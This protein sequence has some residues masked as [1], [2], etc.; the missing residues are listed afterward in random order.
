[1]LTR[2][3]FDQACKIF[4]ESN[5]EWHWNEHPSVSDLGYLSRTTTYLG[6]N[7]S[8]VDSDDNDEASAPMARPVLTSQQF[9]VFSATFQVPCFYFTMYHSNGAPLSLNELLSTTLLRASMLE[10]TE[11][12]SFAVTRQ[13]AMFPLLSQGEHPTTGRPCWYLHPCETNDAVEEMLREVDESEGE[14]SLAWLKMWIV[15]LGS[16]VNL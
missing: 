8:V 16:A 3:Q 5:S 12:T 11:S 2:P 15:V 6:K 9:I 10:N 13:N 7:V 14:R 4:A 1:M